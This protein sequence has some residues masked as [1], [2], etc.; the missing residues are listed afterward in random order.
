MA[1]GALPAAGSEQ[2]RRVTPRATTG[3]SLSF[4]GRLD[5]GFGFAG[6]HVP[7]F[8]TTPESS[9]G[10]QKNEFILP[11]RPF[12]NPGQILQLVSEEAGPSN[13]WT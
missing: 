7:A 11:I 13:E 3:I 6:N 12:Q 5:S 8:F 4:M 10:F 9:A 1:P 2:V